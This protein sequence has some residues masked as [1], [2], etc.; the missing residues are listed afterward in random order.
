MQTISL[1]KEL[2]NTVEPLTSTELSNCIG[3]SSRTIKNY[4][5]EI[6]TIY[7]NSI[8][9]S[10]K[11]YIIDKDIA[12]DLLG[13]SQDTIPQTSIE[14]ISFIINQII[15]RESINIFDLC[16]EMYISYSTLR[17]ELKKVKK[18]LQEANLEL[19]SNNSQLQIRGLEKNKR[20]LLSSIMYSESKNGFI[21]YDNMTKTMHS[22]DI[23]FIKSTIMNSFRQFRYFIND[24][25]LENLIL[26]I[27]ITIDRI[28]N[29]YINN[30]QE[31]SRN[32]PL[33]EYELSKQIIELLER[34]FNIE[35][36]KNEL[37]EFTL[38][39]LS[40]AS[41]LNYLEINDDNII[42]YIGTDIYNLTKDIIEEF[43]LYFYIN[44]S[45]TQFF[46]RFALHIKNVMIRANSGYFSKN[47]LTESIKQNCPLI[48]DAAVNAA[49][50]IYRKKQIY[51]NDDEIAYIAFHIGGAVELQ[52]SIT[53]KITICAYCPNYYDLNT[54]FIEKINSRFHDQ[55][56]LTD[57]VTEEKQLS[58]V[59]TD[60]ILCTLET[61]I[62]THSLIL[63]VSPFLNEIDCTNIEQ[64]IVEIKKRKKRELFKNNLKLLVKPELFKVQE[65][66]QDKRTII[67]EMTSTL[68]SL[69]YVDGNFENEVIERDYI[70]STAFEFFAIPHALQ[71]SALKTG[72]NIMI[73][74]NPVEWDNSHV[75]LIIM[76]AFNK[77]DRYIFNEIF[78]PLTMILTNRENLNRL[79]RSSTYIEFI[80]VLASCI[81]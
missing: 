27:V 5:Q 81:D 75:Q 52:N 74:Q 71:M 69:G 79:L 25:S 38:L 55:V 18:R 68:E 61:H 31:Y 36:N 13:N 35:F 76:L 29:G 66:A 34:H 16:D 33:H 48:Y 51:L 24:Y 59:Q 40:R 23:Q 11:G 43:E 32:I 28:K 49:R 80:N 57:V 17:A 22:D 20:K 53:T 26:H 37:T 10:Q 47:P 42:D 65:Y 63:R 6:N 14:R 2:K 9:S 7:P 60:I 67:H 54:S 45:E 8:I 70:S 4:I 15:Q 12:Q 62:K 72:M 41:N 46:V 39:I 58:S 19:S 64:T 1:I 73:L 78:E 21:G 30:N 50:L 56:I 3:V 77:N 44:L